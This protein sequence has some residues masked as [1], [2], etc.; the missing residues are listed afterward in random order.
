M[1]IVVAVVILCCIFNWIPLI[2]H[3]SYR[4]TEMQGKVSSL[5]SVIFFLF[6]PRSS[7]SSRN[8]DRYERLTMSV[9]VD[10]SERSQAVVFFLRRERKDVDP[11]P[12]VS[13]AS[14][15]CLEKKMLVQHVMFLINLSLPSLLILFIFKIKWM[16]QEERRE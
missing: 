5:L 4:V 16:N 2:P 13:L 12:S 7:S 6:S 1:S 11:F 8:N 3:L 15:F 9:T 10:C 14:F